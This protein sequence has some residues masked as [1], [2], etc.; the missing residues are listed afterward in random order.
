MRTIIILLESDKMKREEKVQRTV[1]GE[2]IFLRCET[3]RY[4]YYVCGGTTGNAYDIIYY[5]G[6]DKWKCT[7]NNVRLTECYHI[8]AVRLFREN[9]KDKIT[10]QD[11]TVHSGII[12]VIPLNT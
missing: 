7:C 11:T 3:D 12:D 10:S 5:K 1:E 4:E 2:K 6:L 8:Q 9:E